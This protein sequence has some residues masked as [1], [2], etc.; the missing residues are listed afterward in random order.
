MKRI[1]SLSDDS[2]VSSSFSIV[3][4]IEKDANKKT[5]QVRVFSIRT[6]PSKRLC[7]LG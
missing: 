3:F 2:K 6:H 4:G 7:L 5:V 1:P